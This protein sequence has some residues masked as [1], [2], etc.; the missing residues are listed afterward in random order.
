MYLKNKLLLGEV[1]IKEWTAQT[2]VVR[3]YVFKTNIFEY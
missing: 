2:L 3:A 1:S